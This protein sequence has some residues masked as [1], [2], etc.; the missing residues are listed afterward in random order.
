MCKVLPSLLTAALVVMLS[1]LAAA[2]ETKQ[3]PQRP[4]PQH[5]FQRLD[6]NHDGQIVPEEV[7]EGAPDRLK[8]LLRRADADGDKKVTMD[9]LVAAVA[10]AREARRQQ[11]PG[12]PHVPPGPRGHQRP[13][14]AGELRWPHPGPPGAGPVP[15]LPSPGA[16]FKRLDTDGDKMLSLQEFTA[17]MKRLQERLR[18]FGPPHFR[19][20]MPPGG[21]AFSRI[22][23]MFKRADVNKDGKVTLKEVP[24]ER[25]EGFKKLLRRADK[26]GDNALSAQE[27]KRLV[28]AMKHRAAVAS[29]AGWPHLHKPQPSAAK[30]HLHAPPAKV[31][32]KDVKAQGA[33]KPKKD[34]QPKKPAAEAKPKPTTADEAAAKQ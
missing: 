32:Q 1:Q 16:I 15:P 34:R 7:P 27:A 5:L 2:D 14:N 18:R 28:V 29:Q 9:E 8:A 31:L 3:R 13:P 6:A 4:D 30:K 22:S 17:G 11:R 10:K 20:P 25:R 23:L 19:G 12:P 33:K 26:D 24:A 21:P